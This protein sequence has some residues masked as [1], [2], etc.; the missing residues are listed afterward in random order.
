MYFISKLLIKM[1]FDS[2]H[3]RKTANQFLGLAY[4]P[5]FTQYLCDR[6]I[7]TT[8]VHLGTD[9]HKSIHSLPIELRT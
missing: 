6:T 4:R 8:C 5:A 2:Q 1:K 3:T 9:L 7:S